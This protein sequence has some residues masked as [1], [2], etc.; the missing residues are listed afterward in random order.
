V[1]GQSK[2]EEGERYSVGEIGYMREP[3]QWQMGW[4]SKIEERERYSVRVK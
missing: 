1:G 2:V 3:G 4:R